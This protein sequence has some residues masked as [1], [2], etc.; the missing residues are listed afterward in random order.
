MS[1]HNLNSIV[2]ELN[3][4]N[5]L[6]IGN[7]GD[8]ATVFALHNPYAPEGVKVEAIPIS[9]LFPKYLVPYAKTVIRT[10]SHFTVLGTLT[11]RTGED[12]KG[13]YSIRATQLTPIHVPEDEDAAD[14]AAGEAGSDEKNPKR[15]SKHRT[16][17]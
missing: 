4:G 1:T 3:A 17:S 14:A 8:F 15:S 6:K 13:Y 16:K 10:G 9:V 5:D 12:S 7:N 2:L 11:Y